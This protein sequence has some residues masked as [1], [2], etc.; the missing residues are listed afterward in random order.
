MS[1]TEYYEY[2]GV[3][4]SASESELKKA[5]LQKAFKLHPDKNPS[6]N[7]TEEFQKLQ[8]IYS[9]LKN[10][11]KRA[12]YDK[13]GVDEENDNESG[14]S[15]IEEGTEEWRNYNIDEIEQLLNQLGKKLNAGNI[16][17]DIS[18]TSTLTYT[19]YNTK[20]LIQCFQNANLQQI[21]RLEL[22][23][24][25]IN[26]IPKEIGLITSLETLILS[27][28]EITDLPIELSNLINLKVLDLGVN[29]LTFIPKAIYFLSSLKE[30]HLE[31][32]K[33]THIEPEISQL[34]NLK[35]LNLFANQLTVIPDEI[36]NLLN[37]KKL[38]FGIN[39]IDEYPPELLDRD[40]ELI[41]DSLPVKGITKLQK[42]KKKQPKTTTTTT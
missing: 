3:S 33:I 32:N 16:I 31:H 2:I 35:V 11:T 17:N 15:D 40:I 21:S 26:S 34:C 41:L 13:Y 1:H 37:I 5:Y 36:C 30:L 4:V 39:F 18:F 24:K 6:K 7:A 14:G 8:H 27:K 22:S 19:T 29:S 12:D 25:A 38:D 23:R 28:N 9:V 42:K 10:P 20:S